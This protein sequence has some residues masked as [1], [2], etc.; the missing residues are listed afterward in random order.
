MVAFISMATLDWTKQPG[1]IYREVDP[2]P[3]QADAARQSLKVM[4]YLR[5]II[6]YH[7]SSIRSSQMEH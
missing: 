3:R 4:N 5:R 1:A 2:S 7:I 6:M